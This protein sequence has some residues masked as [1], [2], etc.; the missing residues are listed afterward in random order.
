MDTTPIYPRRNAN[1]DE[2]I[3]GIL[4]DIA[5]GRHQPGKYAEGTI[6]NLYLQVNNSS[7]LWWRFKYRLDGKAGLHAIGTY[8]NIS[9]DKAREL[10]QEARDNVAKGIRPLDAKKAKEAAERAQQEA[11]RAKG[12][13]TFKKVAEQWLELNSHL[14]PKTLSGYRGALKN[15][16]YP[17]VDNVPVTEIAVRHVRDVLERLATSPTMA[18]R[19]LTLLRVILSHA[20]NHDLISQNVAIGR[21]GLLRKH[22]TKH[23]AALET[24]EDL[25]EF[26]RRLNNFVA[27]NDPVISALWLL[28][29]LPVRPAELT[30][31]K[32][33]EVDIDKAEWRYTVPKTGQPHI[34]PLP[35]QAIAMLRGLKEHSL[36]LAGKGAGVPSPFG[37][38]AASETIEPSIWVFPSSGK[39]GVPI[40]ADTLLVRIRKGLGY[41]R[42]TITS[43]GFRSSWRSIGHE[44]LGIDPIVLELCLGHRMPGALGA[45]YARAQL[46]D[47]RRLAMQKWADYVEG[48]WAS[49][50]DLRGV[51]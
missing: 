25:A 49:V 3:A 46:L 38:T 27:Y 30:A 5:E 7:Q 23:H 36:W 17:V 10:A 28:V 8:P 44:M 29:M 39:F 4:N 32:W 16:L 31:M 24:P 1:S 18:R 21:E 34:V 48:L 19:S 6:K 13:W 33:D 40:S 51:E 20:M 2:N 37:K 9:A 14:K 41:E 50:A 11:E 35:N 47:Q 42:G 12:A 45:T 22:K 15:H 26:L 43:H